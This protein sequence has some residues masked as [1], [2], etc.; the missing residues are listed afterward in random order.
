[1]PL[2][3]A[4]RVHPIVALV[5][6]LALASFPAAPA[7][8]S[9]T[10]PA[11][12]RPDAMRS[13]VLLPVIADGSGV[14]PGAELVWVVQPGAVSGEQRTE[15]RAFP[16]GF[17]VAQ[18]GRLGIDGGDGGP[19]A[20]LRP[21]RARFLS[22]DQQGFFASAS[23]DLV[24]FLQIA[25]VP[26]A[27]APAPLPPGAFASPPFVVPPGETLGFALARGI[28]NPGR[29]A[30]LPTGALPALLLAADNTVQIQQVGR[31][32]RELVRGESTL[33]TARATIHNPGQQPATFLIA[34]VA[35]ITG[36]AVAAE[37]APENIEAS[38]ATA[39]QES[40]AEIDDAWY[41]HGCHRNP[42]NAACTTVGIAAECAVDA[43]SPD[44]RADGDRDGCRDVA[45][46]LSWFDPSDPDDCLGNAA[47]EPAVNCLFPAENRTCAGGRAPGVGSR[48]SGVGSKTE[49]TSVADLRSP[50]TQHPITPSPRILRR[51][52]AHRGPE[53]SETASEPAAPSPKAGGRMRT[54]HRLALLQAVLLVVAVLI[55]L[56]LA[57]SSMSLQLTDGQE[58]YLYEFPSGERVTADDEQAVAGRRSYFN[59]AAVSLDP[60]NGSITLAVSGH[61]VCPQACVALTLTLFSLDADADVR[62]SLPPSAPVTLDPD[63]LIFSDA[64]QLPIRGQPGQYPFDD[65]LLWLGFAVSVTEN[66]ETV[67]LTADTVD[68][69]AVFTTQNQ[70][71]DFIMMPPVA[72]DPEQ[73]QAI[74]V[75]FDFI[76]V[77]EL[78]FD[79]PVH[80]EILTLLLILLISVSAI[81]AVAMRGITDLIVGVG[82]LVLGIW[83]VRSILVPQ[84]LPVVTSVDLALSVVILFVLLALSVRTAHHFH[85]Q[86]E[87]PAFWKR[88]RG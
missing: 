86:A 40:E 63:E 6:V 77:Q 5:G 60:A 48:E 46:V 13:T 58:R 57:F 70:L 56:P 29:V 31:G 34:T 39:R 85:K 80:L 11:T 35:P 73:V 62:R 51:H 67:F 17:A 65:Y 9:A 32:A 66:G 14:T 71:R 15:T 84:P 53:M 1:M 27:A 82:S 2:S 61:R 44:C 55:A 16:L 74:N 20:E 18:R 72:I 41:R 4:S 19:I 81:L 69:H 42:G 37:A 75:P 52:A 47:G 22:P 24:L 49:S 12:P 33:L 28:L 87:L 21:G 88:K 54:V 78:S 36:E 43:T 45:E 23:G 79:R 76:G 83:G 64:V 59:I 26:A 8:P 30:H 7:F 50:P 3:R 68:D 25:L 38:A 10:Q